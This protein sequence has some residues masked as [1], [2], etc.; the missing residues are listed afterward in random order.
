MLWLGYIKA[1]QEPRTT[2][3]PARFFIKNLFIIAMLTI[4]SLS[5]GQSYS[6]DR[7]N[8]GYPDVAELHDS[9]ERAYFLDWFAAIAES[10]YNQIAPDW[11]PR[12]QDC[13]G[14]LRYAFIQALS[15]KDDEW[16]SKY[17]F[18]NVHTPPVH[19]LS[20]PMPRISRSV[21][22]RAAGSF[23]S[24]DVKLGRL[25]GLV[26]AEE[27]MRYASV[28][29]GR[30]VNSARRGDLLFFVHPLAEG[31]GY[32]SMV[33]LGQN[34]A[35]EHMVVYHTGLSPEEGGEVR[36]LSLETLSQHP[37]A[38]WHPISENPH[39]LGFYRWKIVD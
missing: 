20:Y 30:N 29:L 21:F 11:E 8:D 39:F 32:H 17:P 10:Q 27:I 3:K 25:V 38:T 26:T 12:Y 4:A 28:P 9:R 2:S 31:S 7:D 16:F 24:N 19:E 13:S 5:A 22:R 35:G 33:Y 36:L 18:L 1:M 15:P 6:I 34:I 37:D 14:L 23:S